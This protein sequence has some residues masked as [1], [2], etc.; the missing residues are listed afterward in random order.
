METKWCVG[1]LDK[2]MLDDLLAQGNQSHS[3]PVRT[4]PRASSGGVERFKA[5]L[6]AVQICIGNGKLVHYSKMIR[7]QYGLCICFNFKQ[8]FLH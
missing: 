6:A 4:H 3:G 8:D 1:P 7:Q 5:F 2:K